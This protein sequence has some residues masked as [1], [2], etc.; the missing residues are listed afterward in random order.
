MERSVI[1]TV[2]LKVQ[3]VLANFSLGPQFFGFQL[4]LKRFRAQ[5]IKNILLVSDDE[6]RVL[7]FFTAISLSIILCHFKI[8]KNE[9]EEKCN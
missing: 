2:L 4:K 1:R 9:E 6:I 7:I 8:T 5:V 3:A